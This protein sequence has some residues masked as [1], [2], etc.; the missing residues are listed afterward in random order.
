MNRLLMLPQVLFDVEKLLAVGALE[1]RR[2][3]VNHV[4]LK[5]AM[6]VEYLSTFIAGNFL[7]GSW[8]MRSISLYQNLQ[9]ELTVRVVDVI[10]QSG[11][12]VEAFLA[13]RAFILSLSIVNVS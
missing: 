6:R 5:I 3:M 1:G 9:F 12:A 7:F 13:I 4:R 2:L 10:P 8:N 11:V